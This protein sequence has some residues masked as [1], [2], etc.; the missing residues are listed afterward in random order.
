LDNS[1]DDLI[2]HSDSNQRITY[3][4]RAYRDIF[5]ITDGEI[6]DFDF[7]RLIHPEDINRVKDSLKRLKVPPHITHHEERAKTVRGWK[8]FA[9]TVKADIDGGGNIT[10]IKAVGR[11]VTTVKQAQEE[12]LQKKSRVEKV[13]EVGKLANQNL[14]LKPVLQNILQGTV[15]A[16]NASIGMIFLKDTSTGCLNWGA[17]VGLPDAFINDFKDQPIQPGEGLSG[18]IAQAGTPIYIQSDSSHDPRIARRIIIDQNFNSF[19]GVPIIALE[20]IVGVMNIL[21]RSPAILSQED[22]S[23]CAAIGTNVGMAVRNARL[24]GEKSKVEKKLR[25][26]ERKYRLL[27]ENQKD[28]VVKADLSGKFLFVSPSYCKTFGKSEDELL[29]EKY[30]PLVHEAD[31]ASTAKA[32][33]ALYSPPHTAYVEQ[34]AMTKDGWR[35]LAWVDTAILDE[36]GNVKEIIGVGRDIHEHKQM[37]DD[38]INLSNEWQTTFDSTQSAIWILDQDQKVVRS[39]KTAELLFHRSIEQMIGRHCWEII[40]ESK[41]PIPDCPILRVRQSL[42]RES[43]ELQFGEK[44]LHIAADPILDS[45]GRFSGTVHIVSDITE[46]KMVE[47]A[48][49]ES[50]QKYRNLVEKLDDII[51]TTDMELRTVYVSSSVERKLGFSQEERMAQKLEE[52]MTHKSLQKATETFVREL[53]KEREGGMDPNRTFRIELE[54]LHKNGTSIWFENVIGW[55]RD[56]DGEIIGLQGVSRDIT[57][58]INSEKNLAL[59]KLAIDQAFDAIGIATAEGLHFYQNNTF[60]QMF[61]YDVGEVKDLHPKILYQDQNIADEV[62]NTIMGGDNWTGQIT[63]VSKNGRHMPIELRANA[64]KDEHGRVVGLVGI[65]LD[66]SDR[67]KLESRLQQAQK[68]EALGTLAGGIAHDFNNILSSIIGYTELVLDDI[69]RGSHPENNL[70]QVYS[71]GKRAAELVKQILAFARQSDEKIGPIQP[72]SVAKEVL[73]LIRSTIPTTIEIHQKIESDSIILGNATQFHQVFMNL[74]TNAAHAMEESGGVLEVS[75]KEMFIDKEKLSIGMKPG[76][77]VEIRVSDTGPGIPPEIKNSIFDPYFTTK[78]PGEGT[79]MGLAMVQGIV[80]S[81]GGK[82]TFD[83]EMG[84]GAA[85]TIYLPVTKKQSTQGAYVPEKLPRGTERILFIDDEAP[86]AKMGSEILERLGYSVATRTS[87]VEALALFRAKHEEFDLIV[88]DM[89]MPNMTGDNL[90]IELMKIRPDIPIIICTGYSKKIS[91]E[92]ASEIGI[93]AFAYKPVAKADLAKTVRKVLDE[94]KE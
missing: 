25:E 64:I 34:R 62:F 18:R 23:V 54:Y 11:D 77:Y 29:G 14:K 37:E 69:P 82:I 81:Y 84:K 26:S 50:E 4:N 6:G 12:L 20:Q 86:I 71:A 2:V 28:M 48:L 74:C 46:R 88:T 31:R 44:W 73:K 61:G 94:A 16:L 60:T 40:H 90:A 75:L 56:K 8:W 32:M 57:E 89:T 42:K 1:S 83:S 63:M 85:F 38:L 70:Q 78:G 58:R 49:K 51:W 7:K 17:S 19:I 3:A 92:T 91:N 87:S 67:L 43:M 22:L 72:S 80:E 68:M 27:V 66:I 10:G 47:E 21:T 79:G 65:H 76:D 36:N 13:L 45:N 41:Q 39:N 5:G 9:W 15:N 93:K 55:Q 53:E 35:W 52:T 59:F 24:F 30:M 33:E